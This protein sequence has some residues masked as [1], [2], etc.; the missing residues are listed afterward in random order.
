MTPADLKA[1]RAALGMTGAALGRKLELGGRDPGRS[2][3]LWEDG[4]RA[5]PGP[6][7]VAIGYMLADLARQSLQ[8]A[9][10]EARAIIAPTNPPSA[11]LEAL[12]AMEH[13]HVGGP[14]PL[15][16]TRRRGG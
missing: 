14:H 16:T 6:A 13:H 2:V 11:V 10:K 3:R 12:D 4:E 9:I 5:I 8:D 7:R 1:A 15:V